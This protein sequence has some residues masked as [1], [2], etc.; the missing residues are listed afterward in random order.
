[1]STESIIQGILSP[2]VVSDGSTG[3]TTKTDIVNVDNIT[4]TGDVSAQRLFGTSISGTTTIHAPTITGG[5]VNGRL[6]VSVGNSGPTLWSITPYQGGPG[7][8]FSGPV[9]LDGALYGANASGPVEIATH[10]TLTTGSLY[11][12]NARFY[13]NNNVEVDKNYTIRGS[14]H[15]NQYGSDTLDASGTVTITPA[16]ASILSSTPIIMVTPT[17]STTGTLY[18]HNQ[19]QGTSFTVTSSAGA[20]DSGITFDWFIA[21]F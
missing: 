6:S 18:V 4:A 15:P 14:F 1:M 21:K 11:T 2:K 12:S 3:Y 9:I 8:E 19:V 13:F 20:S 16:A 5:D 7:V 10:L 17:S